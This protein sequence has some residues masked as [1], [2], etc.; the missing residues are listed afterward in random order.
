MAAQTT[1]QDITYPSTLRT[2]DE[3]I[4]V[5]MQ[6]I[7]YYPL[8]DHGAL[9]VDGQRIVDTTPAAPTSTPPKPYQAASHQLTSDNLSKHD[10]GFDPLL[11][12]AQKAAKALDLQRAGNEQGFHLDLHHY[13]NHRF[14]LNGWTRQQA[15]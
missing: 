2:D 1:H 12:A 4:T 6:P 5:A 10:K 15:Q 3:G 9:P 7:T 8:A 11:D 14:D 13:T